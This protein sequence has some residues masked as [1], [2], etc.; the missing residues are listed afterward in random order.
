MPIRMGQA[1]LD[2]LQALG[3]G[4]EA[5]NRCGYA[6][7]IRIHVDGQY[8]Q[9][10]PHGTGALVM[11]VWMCGQVPSIYT[12]GPTG[13]LADII[14]W[15]TGQPDQWHFRRGEHGLVLGDDHLSRAELFHEPIRLRRCPLDWMR[16][17]GDGACL[18][19]HSPGVL[20]RLREV[21]EII[22]D[23]LDHG[24]DIERRLQQPAQAVP[25]IFII[26]FE[27]EAA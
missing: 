6:T 3:V 4:F 24:L 19:D 7:A 16:A 12:T 23:D 14:A 11:P 21:G 22:V 13:V 2:R 20:D 15:R 1:G 27:K 25:E 8:W 10:D 18:L 26:N 5:L 9:P 17:A